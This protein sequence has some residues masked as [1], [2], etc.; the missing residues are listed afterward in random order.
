MDDSDAEKPFKC[1]DAGE[2][3]AGRENDNEYKPYVAHS[4]VRITETWCYASFYVPK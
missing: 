2:I 1:R 4:R 3:E